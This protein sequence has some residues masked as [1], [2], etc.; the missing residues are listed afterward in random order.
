L[1]IGTHRGKAAFR[2]IQLRMQPIQTLVSWKAAAQPIRGA[3]LNICNEVPVVHLGFVGNRRPLGHEIQIQPGRVLVVDDDPAMRQVITSY[4][5]QNQCS[6]EGATGTEDI[7][8]QVGAGRF[9]LVILDIHLGERDGFDILR[10]IRARSDIPVIMITGKR[11]DE[12]DRVVGLELGADDYLTKPFNLRE[13]LARARA[14]LRRQE[15]GRQ[16][17]GPVARGGYRFNGWE[18]RRKTR[19]LTD[20]AGDNIILTK[21]EYALLVAFLESPGRPV[22]REHLL[23]ATRTHED[24]YDRSI[25][26]QVLR[27]RRKL[28]LDPSQPTVILTERGVGYIFAVPVEPLF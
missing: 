27:L 1:A 20:P 3:V 6:A 13:L 21:S 4:F 9:G 11:Q 8:Q 15:M 26:V 22:S 5:A 16:S 14:I 28:E 10:Q 7:A 12:V 25:D 2:R 23:Q 24:I 18:L 19:R 17:T